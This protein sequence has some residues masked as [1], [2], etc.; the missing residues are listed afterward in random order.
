M[1]T[2]LVKGICVQDTIV[3]AEVVEK[4]VGPPT[5]KEPNGSSPTVEVQNNKRECIH[6]FTM[7]TVY[8]MNENGKTVAKYD[9]GGWPE[10]EPPK[11]N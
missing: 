3:S 10:P 8:V 6:R 11:K 4:F 7:G 9:L 5:E 1:L 2:V